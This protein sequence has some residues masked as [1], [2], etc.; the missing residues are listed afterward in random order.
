M[1]SIPP[2]NTLIPLS[3]S[4]LDKTLKRNKNNN[5]KLLLLGGENIFLD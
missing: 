1:E 2:L 4:L 3:R 5:K